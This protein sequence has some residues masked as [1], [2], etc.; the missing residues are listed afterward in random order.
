ME[1]PTLWEIRRVVEAGHRELSADIAQLNARLDQYVLREV[2]DAHRG[3]DLE[4]MKRLDTQIREL[5]EQNRKAFW[6]AVSSFIAPILVAIVLAV[7]L[8]GG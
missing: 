6:T 3:A 4:R 8:K 5:R 7:M 2:Y 1:E